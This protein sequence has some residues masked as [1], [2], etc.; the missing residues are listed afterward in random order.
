[1]ILSQYWEILLL[2]Q[3][4]FDNSGTINTDIFT[5]KTSIA[6]NNSGNIN[7]ATF[8]FSNESGNFDYG[9]NYQNSG[10]IAADQNFNIDGDFNN[11][12][13]LLVIL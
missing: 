1:M 2:M 3:T 13:L 4:S 9:A 7:A 5:I 11:T 12:F 8:N 10:T 6:F